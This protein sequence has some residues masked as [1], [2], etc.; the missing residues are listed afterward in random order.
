VKKG[1]IIFASFL[2]IKLEEQSIEML[3]AYKIEFNICDEYH[4]YFIQTLRIYLYT[5]KA[6]ISKINCFKLIQIIGKGLKIHC[7]YAINK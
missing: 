3:T 6:S 5:V 2:I 1:I 4:C 7:D